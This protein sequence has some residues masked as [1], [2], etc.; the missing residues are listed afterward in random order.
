MIVLILILTFLLYR[1]RWGLRLRAV[2]QFPMAAQTAGINVISMK[3]QA[4]LISGLVGGLAGAH[5]SLGYSTMFT[6]NMT[7]N[8]GFMGVAA[9]YFG[10]ANPALTAVGC[11]VFGV[12][13]SV[14]AR[15]QA[16]GL[17]SQF[18]LLMPYVVTIV[19]LSISMISK[20]VATDRKKSSLNVVKQEAI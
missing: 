11:L 3:Y 20:K 9:M 13:D 8:R 10:H 17:P 16:Y 5:L 15:L 14:G 12:A 6:E 1:T 18:V 4:I 19:V 2:G 7:S